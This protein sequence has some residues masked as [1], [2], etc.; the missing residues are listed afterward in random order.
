MPP[1]ERRAAII[2]ATA[3]LLRERGREVSTREIA[4]A[5]GIA[6][7]T[8]F[9]VFASKDDL[10]DAVLEDALDPSASYAALG[11]IDADLPL[12]VRVTNAVAILQ[13]RLNRVF[14]LVY[15]LGF[16]QPPDGKTKPR[17]HDRTME[18]SAL[19]ALLE[20]DAA[21]L[22]TTPE[23][24]AAM[25]G[26]LVLAMSH[27]IIHGTDT[28]RPEPREITDLFLNGITTQTPTNCKEG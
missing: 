21:R 23:R 14:G 13:Q 12:D 9:R 10:I 8:I 22:K 28:P 3:P 2:A 1:Q 7:G 4:E 11:A 27:P 18:T 25:L 6:E 17:P 19:A 24:A 16:R 5:A 15:A 20:P 26:A